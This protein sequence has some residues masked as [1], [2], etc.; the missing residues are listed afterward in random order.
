M[1]VISKKRF[2]GPIVWT[3]FMCSGRGPVAGFCEHSSIKSGTFLDQLS[4]YQHLKK[5][6]V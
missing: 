2:V 5:D 6:L 3:G 1:K 4:D